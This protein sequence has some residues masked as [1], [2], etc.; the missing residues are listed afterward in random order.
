MWDQHHA[1]LVAQTPSIGMPY[2]QMPQSQ[3]NLVMQFVKSFPYLRTPGEDP[4]H[5]YAVV[6][7]EFEF[8]DTRWMHMALNKLVFI[9]YK[10]CGLIFDR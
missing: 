9:V 4:R 2:R 3:T 6:V 7:I 10:Q 8:L 1:H 5:C